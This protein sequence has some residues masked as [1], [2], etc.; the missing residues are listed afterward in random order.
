MQWRIFIVDPQNHIRPH[1]EDLVL[2][3]NVQVY[4]PKTNATLGEILDAYTIGGA[5]EIDRNIF[6][7]DGNPLLAG[8]VNDA[9]YTIAFKSE[10][11]GWH[12]TSNLIDHYIE[13]PYTSEN[14]K[15]ILNEILDI[16][17]KT[18]DK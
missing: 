17:T 16:Y 8:I 11:K 10:Y 14:G 5:N 12:F 13:T 3:N 2:K 18:F 6:V 1:I 9:F 7:Y 15:T 4:L